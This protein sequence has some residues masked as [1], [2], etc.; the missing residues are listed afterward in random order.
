VTT[1]LKIV[2]FQLVIILPFLAGSFFKH[3]LKNADKTA[4]KL[5]TINLTLLEPPV[6]LWSIWGLALSAEMIFLPVS[7]FFLA[8]SGFFIGKLFVRKTRL[9]GIDAD[10]FVISSSL[11]N[12]GFTMG[13]FLCYLFAGEQGLALSAIFLIYFIPFTFLF[14]FPYAGVKSSNQV[15]KWAV[16]RKFLFTFRNMPLYA[17]FAAILI[18]L[19]GIARPDVY[20]PL[21]ILLILFISLYYFTLGINFK[22]DDLNV[23]KKEHVLM[24]IQKFVILP[25]I[26]FIILDFAPISDMTKMII[27]IESFMPAAIYSVITAILFDLNP[28]KASN[29]FVVNSLLFIFFVLP[30]L[31]YFRDFLL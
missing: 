10:T 13:G 14:I 23:F 28:R 11:A 26:I 25:A 22:P 1:E 8:I 3:R 19:A 27:K 9:T 16:V 29:L 24:A 4:K 21:D 6:A 5:I 20:F 15:F 18:R 12:H 2:I 31:F 30:L 7:G 17:V